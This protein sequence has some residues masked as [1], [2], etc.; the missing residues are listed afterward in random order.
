MGGKIYPYLNKGNPILAPYV[1]F[2]FYLI[3]NLLLVLIFSVNKLF[4]GYLSAVF[5]RPLLCL[6]M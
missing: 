3:F 6:H 2:I 5:I 4:S 1:F